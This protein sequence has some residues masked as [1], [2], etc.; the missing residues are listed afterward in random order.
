MAR[1][2]SA[3]LA[4]RGWTKKALMIVPGLA[5]ALGL[6]ALGG[7]RGATGAKAGLKPKA[8]APPAVSHSERSTRSVTPAT[9]TPA[10]LDAL[11]ESFL[12]PTKAPRAPLTSD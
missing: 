1:S 10:G 3:P 2:K 11:V 4:F 8:Q 7:E 5:C 6:A 9:L 12:E